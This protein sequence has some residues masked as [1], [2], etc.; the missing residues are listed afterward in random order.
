MYFYDQKHKKL[1]YLKTRCKDIIYISIIKNMTSNN[2]TSGNGMTSEETKKLQEIEDIY[3][4]HIDRD[5][6]DDYSLETDY[7]KRC[8]TTCM[9]TS[10]KLSNVFRLGVLKSLLKNV[11]SDGL[12]MIAT[13]RDITCHLRGSSL[14]NHIELL[15]SLITITEINEH[16]RLMV[17][18]TLYNNGM[19]MESYEG[20]KIL[21]QDSKVKLL[22]RLESCRYLFGSEDVEL[23]DYCQQCLLSIVNSDEYPCKRRYE[24]IIEYVT[25]TGIHTVMNAAKI[26]VGYD[27][28]FVYGLQ[29]AFFY[30][31]TND[32]EYRILSGQHILDME[33][34][35][36][37]KNKVEDELY[38]IAS[39]KEQSENIRAQASDSLYR[40]SERYIERARDIFKELRVNPDN[41]KGSLED[42]M[43]ETLHNKQNVHN[44]E[45]TKL[46][47]TFIEKLHSMYLS[48]I[49]NR[50]RYDD[51]FTEITRYVKGRDNLSNTDR[52]KIRKTLDRI[53]VD[54][55]KFTEH[56]I[57]LS[58]ILVYVWVYLDRFLPDTEGTDDDAEEQQLIHNMLMDRFIDE[59]IDM[60]GWCSSGY[61]TRLVN[62]FNSVDKDLNISFD[63]EIKSNIAGRINARIRELDEEKKGDIT[64]G[65]MDTA[66]VEER[67]VYRF[68]VDKWLEEIRKELLQEYV[69]DGGYI[70]TN[71]FD[72]CFE[73]GK[74][75]W[76]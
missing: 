32:T 62:V 31:K 50:K 49:S 21:A 26:K 54:T 56:K 33:I 2:A 58:N 35:K 46:T 67:A 74:K 52:H 37:S 19:T 55:S 20:F 44:D 7:V 68:H 18:L 16:D 1:L 29:N 38:S 61:S 34:D 23:K 30:N 53:N 9:D 24:V 28:T 63:E 42:R 25:N 27:E 12:D 60:N 72:R 40:L 15:S 65:M 14:Y 43:S 8:K 64:L 66:T 4:S 73:N 11:T 6:E 41:I 36:E 10:G 75:I 5:D 47:N 39:D 76:M 13:W 71:D 70:S 48:N 57:F 69:I 59:L 51:V 17:T 22:N 45:I 3:K